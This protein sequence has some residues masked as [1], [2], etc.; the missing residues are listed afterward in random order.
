MVVNALLFPDNEEAVA[1]LRAAAEEARLRFNLD[2]GYDPRTPH[3]GLTELG[4]MIPVLGSKDDA[5]CR[6]VRLG[7]DP[8][9][10]DL[11]LSA[12]N[13]LRGRTCRAGHDYFYI[14]ID[15]DVYRCSRYQALGKDRL[16]N[17]LNEGFELE[18]NRDRWVPCHAGFGCG[19][20]E[21]FLNLRRRPEPAT[22]PLPSLGWV[23]DTACRRSADAR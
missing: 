21:D 13:D 17:V 23:D 14:G 20:K 22:T 4:S 16:G 12:M 2:L 9:I 15:G 19:N 5:R 11:N 10:L 18:L 8:E 3:A 6:A 7:A 1:E